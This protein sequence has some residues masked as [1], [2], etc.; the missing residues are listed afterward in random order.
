MESALKTR[1]PPPPSYTAVSLTFDSHSF[2]SRSKASR[3]TTPNVHQC[4]NCT[5]KCHD[6]KCTGKVPLYSSKSLEYERG[7]CS[8]LTSA[9][10]PLSSLSALA[11]RRSWERVGVLP[12]PIMARFSFRPEVTC[13]RNVSQ[14]SLQHGGCGFTPTSKF[15]AP[16]TP[17]H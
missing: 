14:H 4:T 5:G 7:V 10:S 12:P 8:P 6:Y 3:C 15:N 13:G 9:P 2:E 11:S 1:P 17:L 16:P